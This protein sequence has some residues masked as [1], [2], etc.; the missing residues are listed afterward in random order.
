M[1]FYGATQ[2]EKVN[3]FPHPPFPTPT[4]QSKPSVYPELYKG[5]K[6]VSGKMMTD[7]PESSDF[8]F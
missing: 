8:Y 7:Q 1:Y 6:R 2:K 3:A 4:K 5:H